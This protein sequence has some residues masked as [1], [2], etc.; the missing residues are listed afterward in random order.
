[1]ARINP[2]HE[3]IAGDL[4]AR[5]ARGELAPGDTL[6]SEHDLMREYSVS[7]GTVRQ[8]RAALSSEGVIGGS[9]GR[10]FVVTRPLLTQPLHQLVS[11]SAW[12]EDL[13]YVPSARVTLFERR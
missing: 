4:R 2:R 12:A 11:F 10:R 7:R 1:M 8:A 3:Q 5:I 9:Q 6:P 13:G